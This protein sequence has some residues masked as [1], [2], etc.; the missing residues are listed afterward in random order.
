MEE[1]KSFALEVIQHRAEQ[2]VSYKEPIKGIIFPTTGNV[3]SNPR[4]QITTAMRE[5]TYFPKENKFDFV[6]LEYPLFGVMNFVWEATAGS[7]SPVA[8][9]K[10]TVYSLQFTEELALYT[11][12]STLYADN[13]AWPLGVVVSCRLSVVR[14]AGSSFLAE[15]LTAN[16]YTL[17]AKGRFNPSINLG[18]SSLRSCSSSREKER[19]KKTA[20]IDGG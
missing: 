13:N 14:E 3:I 4:I 19:R 9:V 16:R 1:A 7:S 8:F 6:P 5:Y 18:M 12:H 15:P 10:F 17:T 20:K 11:V 2:L